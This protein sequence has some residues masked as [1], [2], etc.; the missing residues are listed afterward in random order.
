MLNQ[1]WHS[2]SRCRCIAFSI[3][4][5]DPHLES[6]DS[7][8]CFPFESG[9]LAANAKMPCRANLTRK[10][11]AVENG[12]TRKEFELNTKPTAK[13]Q[14]GSMHFGDDFPSHGTASHR[15]A[16]QSLVQAQEAVAGICDTIS[17][18][19]RQETLWCNLLQVIPPQHHICGHRS[20]SDLNICW[21]FL[22]Q[23]TQ[24]ASNVDCEDLARVC[25]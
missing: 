22:H 15:R 24:A 10:Q 23:S 8:L 5:Y 3:P 21:K 20:C 18:L 17:L 1:Q 25:F 4:L 7:L 13:T 16:R 14:L 9:H 11:I 2:A 12:V 6:N 19:L